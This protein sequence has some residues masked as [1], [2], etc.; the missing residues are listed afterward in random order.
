MVRLPCQ[1]IKLIDLFSQSCSITIIAEDSEGY[2]IVRGFTENASNLALKGVQIG[3]RILAVGSTL[4]DIMWPVSTVEGVISACTARLPGQK[5]TMRFERT[6]NKN[7][8]AVNVS[9][10]NSENIAS[11]TGTSVKEP[12]VARQVMSV[13]EQLELLRRC[14]QVLKRYWSDSKT[15]FVGKNRIQGLVAD[16]VVDAVA[17]ASAS[18]DAVTLSMVMN[19]YLSCERPDAAIHIFQAAT[20]LNAD[21][22]TDAHD[23]VVHGTEQGVLVV[24]RDAVNLFTASSAMQA[25]AMKGDF[26]SAKRILAAIEGHNGILVDGKTVASWPGTGL[27]GMVQSDTVCYNTAL[28]A[29]ASSDDGISDLLTLFSSMSDQG[30]EGNPPVKDIVSYN[31]VISALDKAGRSEEALAVFCTLKQAGI[32]PDKFTYTSL[33]RSCANPLDVQ[34][35]LYDMKE[36][37]V[38][39]DIVTYNTVIKTLCDRS[40]W[41]EAKNM[42]FDM[43]SNGV[44]PNSMT[45]GLLMTGLMKAGKHSSCLSLFESAC[46]DPNTMALTENVHLYTTAISAAASL[47]NHEKAF[48][49]INRMK[50]AGVRPNMKSMSALMSACLSSGMTNLA[51]D[52][53]REIKDPDGI[54]MTKGL[55]A[56]AFEG[57]FA[58]VSV[59]LREQWSSRN[60]VMSGKQIMDTYT[61]LLK[62]ALKQGNL[63]SARTAFRQL[64]Q[65]G[66][67]PSRAM[68]QAVIAGLDLVPPR[69]RDLPFA[70]K[71]PEDHFRFLLFV[72]DSIGNRN[73]GCDGTFYA[74]TLLA[75]SRM[76]GLYRKIG[77]LLAEARVFKIHGDPILKDKY[78]EGEHDCVRWESLSRNYDDFKKS[79]TIRLPRCVVCV[80]KSFVGQNLSAEK[81]VTPKNRRPINHGKIKAKLFAV[82]K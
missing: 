20:G 49:L 14:R 13:Q 64:L 6:Y 78:S 73:L 17:S 51:V 12:L 53:Y 48:H 45:Y 25:Y 27:N 34:E 68:Y 4:G 67:I 76:G 75:A 41:F 63:E 77:S 72:L 61:V 54:A 36:L 40:Q 3:D 52:V 15:D 22:S 18:L 62:Q 50:E 23:S 80:N 43:E 56:M 69:S 33:I 11:G 21:G 81:L 19:A 29:A 79:N 32:K 16:K 58:D 10:Y 5:V 65:S 47:K 66:F 9:V 74:T 38:K 71:I 44:K 24:N 28:S 55:E 1:L 8:C 7:S 35:L 31:T 59:C 2:V 82:S 46:S 37:G 30:G 39:P 42:I 70:K 57:N 26:G 60:K